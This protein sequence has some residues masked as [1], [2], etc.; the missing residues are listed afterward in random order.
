MST[1]VTLTDGEHEIVDV[2]RL[3]TEI[4]DLQV[5]CDDNDV[6]GDTWT[7]DDWKEYQQSGLS[8]KAYIQQRKQR[9]Q[10]KQHKQHKQRK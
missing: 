7:S 8:Y 3:N 1:V 9:K 2:L 10:H 6:H 4:E 5:D